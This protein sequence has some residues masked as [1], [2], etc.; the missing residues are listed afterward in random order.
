[1]SRLFYT[2]EAGRDWNK[3][4]PVGNGRLGAMIF[5]N[6]DCERLQLNQ[7]SVWY[8]GPM[9]RVNQDAKE[10]LSEVRSLILSGRISEAE[11]L[12][13]HCFTAT[14]QSERTYSTLGD[15]NI[16]YKDINGPVTGYERELDLNSAV[17]RLKK[18]YNGITYREEIFASN[19]AGLIVIR[20]T[21]D[22]ARPFDVDVTFGRMTFYDSSFHDGSS[23]YSMGAMVGEDYR[24][25]AGL[26]SFHS[27]GTVECQGEYLVCRGVQELCLLFTA[28]TTFYVP[29]PLAEVRY[30][31]NAGRHREYHELYEEHVKDYRSLFTKT[32]FAFSYDSEMD[33]VP[34]DDRLKLFSLE[35]PDNGLIKTYFDFGRYLLIASSREGSLPANLQGIWNPHMDPPW[36]SKF[37]ININTEMNYWPAEMFGLGTCHLPLFDL[38]Q[39]MSETGQ[40]TA[41]DMYGC[42]GIVAHH[43]TDMWGDTAPQ[44]AWIPATYW[45]MGLAW[46]CTHIWEHYRYSKDVA[47]LEKM[48]PV[49]RDSVQFFH[50]FL[51]EKEDTVILCPSLSP[52][53]TYR[54]P[55]GEEGHLCYNSTMDLEILR[56]LFTEF[57]KAAEILEDAD[58]AFLKKTKELLSKI[59]PV[60][61]G[62]Y[63]QVME[64]PEDYE[65]LEP[66]HRHISHLYALYPSD[67]IHADDADQSLFKAASVTLQRRLKNGGGHTGWSRAWIMNMY[68]R[69]REGEKLYENLTALLKRSTLDNLLDNHPPFQIDGNFG[70]IAAIGEAFLYSGDNYAVLLPALPK[71]F[72]DGFFKGLC[73]RGGAVYNL[74]VE[75]GRLTRFTVRAEMCD[76]NAEIRYRDRTFSVALKQGEEISLEA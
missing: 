29:D 26:S 30:V 48:Y 68:A 36:G 76:Y 6:A 58:E 59:P 41:R 8:G 27:G 43:N 46:L 61:I 12:L 64:W 21:N 67:Q 69:L 57:L 51:I 45:V 47:F 31:L 71:Q 65:E 63:G 19:P 44:D 55:N 52:E 18:T 49:M 25:V 40:K 37:T 4:L 15:L 74:Y 16:R 66:G 14:P 39:R 38:M 13:L 24:Y 50:D 32:E 35:S 34:T 62:Q 10:H 11:D 23:I 42:R 20:I 33:T 7:D 56:D 1:M 9:S 3:A 2:T 73:A 17:F 72:G 53:N 75:E 28:T 60:R 70:A 5:G 54:L 22:T